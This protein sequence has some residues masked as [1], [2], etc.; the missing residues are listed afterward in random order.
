MSC[1]VL[2]AS[3]GLGFVV[4]D[5]LSHSFSVF[6]SVRSQS[7]L[8]SSV[9]FSRTIVG[10][11][12]TD[13]FWNDPILDEFSQDHSHVI[14]V[15]TGHC[16]YESIFELSKSKLDQYF[17][18][19]LYPF[20]N[21][22]HF[23]KN[24]LYNSKVLIIIINTSIVQDQDYVIDCAGYQIAKHALEGAF[25]AAEVDTWC[26]DITVKSMYPSNYNTKLWPMSFGVPEDARSP[27]DF[28][29]EVL[30]VV[31]EWCNACD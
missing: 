20:I 18:S 26:T 15:A 27:K 9:P 2:G 29:E 7:S 28:G 24:K 23:A 12:S 8:P 14:V 11:P 19:H 4:C 31:L 22:V 6:G 1:L 25:R 16:N 21:A 13:D 3:G 10:L 17:E 30:K 5:A